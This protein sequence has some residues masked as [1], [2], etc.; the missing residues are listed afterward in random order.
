[1]KLFEENSKKSEVF[2]AYHHVHQ[3]I[4][5][6]YQNLVHGSIHNDTIFNASRFLVN[7]LAQVHTE[8]VNKVYIYY[9]LSFMATKFEAFKT[10]RFGYDKL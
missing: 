6:P 8:G 1:M 4:E 9:A 10:A 3:L 2:L 5:N 7:N